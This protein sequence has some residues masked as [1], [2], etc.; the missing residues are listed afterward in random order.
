MILSLS[1]HLGT[2]FDVYKHERFKHWGL[3]SMCFCFKRFSRMDGSAVLNSLLNNTKA[4]RS[5]TTKASK[6][7]FQRVEESK[8]DRSININAKS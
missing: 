3:A 1:G 6:D 5:S 8:K 7:F 4:D 2:F